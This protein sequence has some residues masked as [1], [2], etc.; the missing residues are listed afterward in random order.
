M[1]DPTTPHARAIVELDEAAATDNEPIRWCGLARVG[2][3]LVA[4]IGLWIILSVAAS[5]L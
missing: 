1:I 5:A 2:L 4:A 3:I